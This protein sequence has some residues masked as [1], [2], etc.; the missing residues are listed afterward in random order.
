MAATT[1]EGVPGR[2][3][4]LVLMILPLMTQMS[5]LVMTPMIHPRT[6]LLQRTRLHRLNSVLGFGYST[7]HYHY[8][9]ISTTVGGGSR[10]T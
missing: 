5:L 6:T 8:R 4:L 7:L 3:Q 9:R 1:E 10:A 2:A